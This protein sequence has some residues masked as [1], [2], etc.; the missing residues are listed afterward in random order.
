MSFSRSSSSLNQNEL[1]SVADRWQAP[2]TMWLTCTH[3]VCRDVRLWAWAR[4]ENRA[5]AMPSIS[6]P[7]RSLPLPSD[8]IAAASSPSPSC[9]CHRTTACQTV[10]TASPPSLLPHHRLR[11]TVRALVRPHCWCYR[12]G[13]LIGA[14]PCSHSSWPS[15]LAPF[16]PLCSVA[17][18]LGSLDAHTLLG[19]GRHG[20]G[21]PAHLAQRHRTHHCRWRVLLAKPRNPKA[22]PSVRNHTRSMM[23][24]SVS[25]ADSPAASSRHRSF[26]P[27][28]CFADAWAPAVSVV[29]WELAVGWAAL[30][31]QPR[32]RVRFRFLFFLFFYLQI[33]VL[34][35]KI[36]IWSFRGPIDRFQILLCSM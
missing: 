24:P 19:S 34:S 36:H 8:A 28:L 33:W 27:C 23:V 29:R 30:P 4:G 31:G 32:S 6:T 25:P 17:R 16:S 10:S 22:P 14:P 15:S 5:Q 11:W 13:K 35:S 20:R 21:W 18:S 1:S 3:V 26:L 9:L 7:F 12:R 2:I